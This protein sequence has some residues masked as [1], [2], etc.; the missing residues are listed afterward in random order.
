MKIHPNV[1]ENLP[2]KC[3]LEFTQILSTS[4]HNNSPIVFTPNVRINCPFSVQQNSSFYLVQIMVTLGLG[5]KTSKILFCLS[6]LTAFSVFLLFT[7]II[8]VILTVEIKAT[9]VFFFPLAFFDKW[10][11][12]QV[13]LLLNLLNGLFSR[14]LIKRVSFFLIP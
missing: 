12:R 2:R 13:A 6:C 7:A 10:P 5:W 11:F 4:V 9:I 14:E 3:P 8:I 1:H